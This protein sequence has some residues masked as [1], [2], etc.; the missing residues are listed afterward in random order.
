VRARRKSAMAKKELNDRKMPPNT[1]QRAEVAVKVCSRER[2]TKLHTHNI[3]KKTEEPYQNKREWRP[4]VK[5][6]MEK[7]QRGQSKK[8]RK[9]SKKNINLLNGANGKVRKGPV[10]R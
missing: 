6:Q 4:F 2:E 1:V 5:N 9:Q 10:V 8:A 7:L 3:P